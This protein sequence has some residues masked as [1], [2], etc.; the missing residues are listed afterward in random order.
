MKVKPMLYFVTG[1]DD[2]LND[3]LNVLGE[4][5]GFD[6]RICRFDLDEIQGC[7]E[8][9]AHKKCSGIVFKF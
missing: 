4:D 2:K 1:N 3:A 5:S 9:I 8:E 7:P 6:L